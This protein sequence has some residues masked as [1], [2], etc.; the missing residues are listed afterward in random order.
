[1]TLVD[2]VLIDREAF[3]IKYDDRIIAEF[4]I[5]NWFRVEWLHV[6][7]MPFRYEL[8]AVW[9]FCETLVAH[10]ALAVVVVMLFFLLG[11]DPAITPIDL[12]AIVAHPR[13]ALAM[14][15]VFPRAFWCLSPLVTFATA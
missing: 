15:G 1:M 13:F 12:M 5:N 11:F 9:T 8:L 4:R 3:E 10:A 2:N 6:A 7:P 14:L